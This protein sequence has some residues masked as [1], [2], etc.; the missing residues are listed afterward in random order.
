MKIKFGIIILGLLASGLLFQQCQNDVNSVGTPTIL[1][2]NFYPASGSG[3]VG[4]LCILSGSFYSTG[5]SVSNVVKFNG[6]EATIISSTAS[7]ITTTVPTGAT[8]GKIT[9]TVGNVTGTSDFDFSVTSG[10]PAP[11]ILDFS[12]KSGYGI[13]GTSVTITGVNFAPT[14]GANTVQFNGTPATVVSSSATSVKVTV[15]PGTTSGKITLGVTGVSTATSTA[16]FS[17]PS[18]AIS[19]FTPSNTIVGGTVVIS[20]SNFSTTAANNVVKFN[21]TA[22]TATPQ[23]NDKGTTLTVVVPAGATSGKITVSVDGQSTDSKD[24]FTVN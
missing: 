22:V 2:A 6:V 23:V 17:V 4:T 10:Q 11:Y 24:T 14:N 3:P 5:G 15:A 9:V 7:T 13:D 12:P 18:P 1:K 20:G 21:G 16:D 8:S 19:G